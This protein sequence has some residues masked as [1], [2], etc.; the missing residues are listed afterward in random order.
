MGSNFLRSSS[1]YGNTVPI[2]EIGQKAKEPTPPVL[3]S[4]TMHD[5]TKFIKDKMFGQGQH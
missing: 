3:I 2:G 1:F 4:E 5:R